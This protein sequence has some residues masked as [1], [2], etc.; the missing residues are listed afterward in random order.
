MDIRS[1]PN[2]CGVA[3]GA[4]VLLMADV[5]RMAWRARRTSASFSPVVLLDA[6]LEAVGETGTLLI[7]TY[8]FD[9]RSG[10][11]YDVLRTPPTTG[12]LGIAALAH[13]S[14]R[15]T[16]HPL[17]SFAVAGARAG[18][19]LGSDDDS[20]FG[21]RSPFALLHTQQAMQV[22]LDLSLNDALTYVHHV[23][24]LEEV[25]YRYWRTLHLRY[26]DAQGN[27]TRKKFR[28]FAKRTGHMNAFT[29][30]AP[31]LEAGN[32][33]RRMDLDGTVCL[34]VDLERAHP[35]IAHDIHANNARHI[36]SFTFDRWWRDVLRTWLMGRERSRSA[37][38]LETHAADRIG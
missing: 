14:F 20:S 31:L 7:P 37:R 36:H 26:T 9:L 15:R 17:H 8:N 16:A 3:R 18:E 5:T 24:E 22:A 28:Q 6:F 33:L 25:R 13:P 30:L 10:E 34:T 2:R 35:I 32:A 1:W 11:A 23:E 21:P 29:G 19:Y 4:T 27:E 12:V 38:S